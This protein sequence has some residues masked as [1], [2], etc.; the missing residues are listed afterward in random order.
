MHFY[1]HAQENYKI[2][3]C[4]NIL[5]GDFNK[6]S[7]RSHK[8]RTKEIHQVKILNQIMINMCFWV[9]CSG[10]MNLQY[11]VVPRRFAL[12]AAGNPWR[13]VKDCTKEIMKLRYVLIIL[14]AVFSRCQ[15]MLDCCGLYYYLEKGR[16]NLQA[17][18]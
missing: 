11:L 6:D 15:R 14:L 2:K 4:I 9:S 13:S 10:Q 16:L 3:R 12:L 17:P 1:C 5:T 8:A 18:S 7:I